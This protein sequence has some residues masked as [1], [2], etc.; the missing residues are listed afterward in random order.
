[1][2]QQPATR[3]RDKHWVQR[4]LAR[5][6]CLET[7]PVEDVDA[8]ASE[9]YRTVC[10]RSCDGYFFP[11]GFSQSKSDFARHRT[12]CKGLYGSA[13][14]DLYFYPSGKTADEMVSVEGKAYAK[15]SFAFAFQ[16][17]F[18]P[19]CQ[20][21][22]KRGFEQV[23]DAFLA[24]TSKEAFRKFKSIPIPVP[25]PTAEDAV[26][27]NDEDAEPPPKRVS[28]IIPSF[29]VYLNESK[30]T[31][32]EAVEASAAPPRYDPLSSL[33]DLISPP[34]EAAAAPTEEATEPHG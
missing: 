34:A 19:A 16:R 18:R 9:G 12:M 26:V 2:I 4:E 5:N 30:V 31:S 15:Q 20:A 14:A 10:V 23:R 28:R 29:P 33:L 13:S 3:P 22:L 27:A 1:M 11:M 7:S 24:E 17:E 8:A 21:E 25:R 6:G 32:R